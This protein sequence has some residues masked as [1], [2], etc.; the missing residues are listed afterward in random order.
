MTYYNLFFYDI[1]AVPRT[2]WL[3]PNQRQLM[4]WP[5]EELETRRGKN[6]KMSHQQLKTGD[7]I[8][9]KGITAAQVY[10]ENCL[11]ELKI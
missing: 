10:F 3:D 4:Q 2:V 1:Q 8:E 11:L 5:I 6:V 9:V 7:H